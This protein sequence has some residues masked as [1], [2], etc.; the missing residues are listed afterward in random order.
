MVTVIF[1][2]VTEVD[3]SLLKFAVIAARYQNQWVLC[4]HKAR[5][6]WEIPGGHREADELIDTTAR[7]E[8]WE[9]TGAVDASIEPVC[10]YNVRKDGTPSYGMLYF[11]EIFTLDSLP[12]GSEIGEIRLFETLPENLT[13]PA[14]QPH[15]HRYI[16]RWK[17]AHNL[18]GVVMGKCGFYCGGCP[19]YL[20]GSCAG[21][22]D[23]HRAGDCFTRDC[24]L[25]RGIPVCTMCKEFPCDTILEKD[26]CTVLDKEWLRWK[27]RS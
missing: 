16:L 6:T 7:R 19:T 1:H 18:D 11:A 20:K 17:K 14:I 27:K 2:A 3:D 21:C 13:Y 23:A 8:L 15:L 9:E 5:S 26:R 4:R 22:T 10:I 24:V 12:E 25:R